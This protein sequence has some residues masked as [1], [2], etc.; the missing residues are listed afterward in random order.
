VTARVLEML[1]S[2]GLAMEPERIERGLRYLEAEQEADGSWFGRW[3]VNYLYGTSGVISALAALAPQRYQTQIQRAMTWIVSC[4][5]PDGGWGETCESYRDVRLK[6]KGISTASQTAWA[7]IALLDGG[8]ATGQWHQEALERGINYL[9]STQNPD[10]SWD[11]AEFTGTGFPCHF[12]I[13]Y[14]FYRQYFPLMALG[15]YQSAQ[16]PDP[17]AKN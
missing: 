9:M 17:T 13:R 1:G 8:Q 14:H 15:R 16:L 6:G 11:E 7:L 10:G 12:Y 3:G 5:N 4:Q 2:C